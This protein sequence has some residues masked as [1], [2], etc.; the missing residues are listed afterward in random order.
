MKSVF[1]SCLL[2]TCIAMATTVRAAPPPPDDPIGARLLPPELIMS[3]QQEIGL[4][5]QT[6][7][8]C[9]GEIQRFQAVT[10][11]LQWDLKAAVEQLARMLGGSRIDE[12]KALAQADRVMA[13]E[14]ELK[15]AHLTL[16]IRL[17]NRLTPAQQA[18]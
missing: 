16:L 12:A 15:K 10:M 7:A 17:K 1:R 13:I 8:A 2:I 18:K 14:H 9:I 3:H 11:K 4:D 5:D 6:R